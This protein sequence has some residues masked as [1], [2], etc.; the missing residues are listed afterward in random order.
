MKINALD[1]LTM[2]YLVARGIDIGITMTHMIVDIPGV[3][4]LNPLILFT[5]VI[6]IPAF[7]I[8]SSLVPILI[9]YSEP[10][11]IRRTIGMILLNVLAWLIV[12]SNF[13]VLG[14]I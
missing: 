12:M 2:A 11:R 7:M 3:Q 8:A 5:P 6:L 9:V 13:I 4:E 14:G 10:K 1:G